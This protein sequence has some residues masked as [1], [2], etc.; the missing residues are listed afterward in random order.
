ML[1]ENSQNIIKGKGDACTM[2][3]SDLVIIIDYKR[4]YKNN[5]PNNNYRK[6]V[7]LYVDESEI[8]QIKV[9]THD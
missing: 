5:N 1:R 7:F 9:S 6:K 2:Y 8:N 4:P 3:K